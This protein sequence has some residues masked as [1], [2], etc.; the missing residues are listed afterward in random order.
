MSFIVRDLVVPSEESGS[1]PLT[2]GIR[3]YRQTATTQPRPPT[4]Q[5]GS[6]K[7]PTEYKADPMTGPVD[8]KS[9][10]RHV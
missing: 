2:I 7:P 10:S 1:L 8:K 4:T 6:P 5:N 9:L 3:K